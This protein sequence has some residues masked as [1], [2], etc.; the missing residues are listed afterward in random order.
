MAEKGETKIF[1]IITIC[2]MLVSIGFA[3]CIE[4]DENNEK[5]KNKN[6]PFSKYL[7][8]VKFRYFKNNQKEYL[9]S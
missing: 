8:F 7:Q 1:A 9:N 5:N 2:I 6:R 4:D 3:G